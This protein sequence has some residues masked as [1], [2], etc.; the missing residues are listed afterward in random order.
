M[1]IRI[2]V[3]YPNDGVYDAEFQAFTPPGVALHFTRWQIPER[4][5][6]YPDSS[7]KMALLA[8]DPGLTHCASMFDRIG[9]AAVTLGCT[10]VGFARGA[11]GDAPILRALSAGT[12]APTSSTSTGYAAV[13]QAHGI[14][15]VAISSVYSDKL[16]VRFVEF[17]E[18]VGVRSVNCHT[19]GWRTPD[20]DDDWLKTE[21]IVERAVAVDHPDAQAILIPET[22]ISA[23]EAVKEIERRLNKPAI[24]AI[25]VTMWDAL[26]LAGVQWRGGV[27]AIWRE[28][29]SK[30]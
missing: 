3:I 4:Q 2:G 18:A 11:N 23:L 14:K 7:V 15:N 24:S 13:C 19:F 25:Q 28:P 29:G 9:A 22:N 5:W 8:D 17:L 20:T 21:E 1:T 26:R 30:V 16:T 12:K 10:S 27:G 6:F